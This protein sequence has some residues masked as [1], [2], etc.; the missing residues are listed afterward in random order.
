[1]IRVKIV[2]KLLDYEGPDDDPEKLYILNT[3]FHECKH[4]E[5]FFDMMQNGYTDKELYQYKEH[6]IRK[7]NTGYY[8]TNYKNISFENEAREYGAGSFVIFL[9]TF[10]PEMEK[11]IMFYTKK[12]LEEEKERNEE[13]KVFELSNKVTVEEA[14]DKLVSINPSIINGD[15]ILI[16][17]YDLDG[18][19][20]VE[21]RKGELK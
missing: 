19:K 8:N 3:L 17:E 2:K 15:K 11:S 20:K 12:M 21:K 4:I 13:R 1:M 5:Q 6:I 14:F 7:Y 9:N 18:T 16:Q 10:F